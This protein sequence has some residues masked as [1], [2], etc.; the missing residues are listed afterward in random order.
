MDYYTI[1]NYR[2]SEQGILVYPSNLIDRAINNGNKHLKE[3][4]GKIDYTGEISARTRSKISRIICLWNASLREFETSNSLTDKRKIRKLVA[5][6]LTL[7]SDT[8]K[9][10]NYIKR[11]CLGS[12]LVVL[13][14]KY[15]IT[16]YMW[17]AE[18]QRNGRIHFHLII[19]GY[20]PKDVLNYEWDRIMSNVLHSEKIKDFVR[21]YSS[22][23]TRIEKINSSKG[24]ATYFVKYITKKTKTTPDGVSLY[25]KISGRVWGMADN[26]RNLFNYNFESSSE[27][28]EA[29]NKVMSC[30]Q[31][32][33]HYD[34]RFLFIRCPLNVF[35]G[36]FFPEGRFGVKLTNLINFDN[37]YNSEDRFLKV[38]SNTRQP[39]TCLV[40]Q[41]F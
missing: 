3:N 7:S 20:I 30:K 34:D 14:R 40:K 12:F 19:D 17:K 35:L 26:L 10:D 24:F 1:K 11:H 4:W 38:W 9:D 31:F 32:T 13:K 41:E 29:I 15:S 8:D 6:T 37:L 5:V 39:P 25:R 36:K 33:Y 16:N 21:G 28:V 22:P 2:L 27:L 18:S 23:S